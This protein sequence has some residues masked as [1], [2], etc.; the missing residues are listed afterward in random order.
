MALELFLQPQWFFPP[1]K[2]AAVLKPGRKRDITLA[3][4]ALHSSV[5]CGIP[6]LPS[7]PCPLQTDT[8]LEAGS[9]SHWQ[10]SQ[11]LQKSSSFLP[12]LIPSELLSARGPVWLMF[13]LR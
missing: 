5:M 2:C 1:V 8:T 11:S 9:F 12:P 3:Y 10:P 6:P 7:R 4:N 13:W